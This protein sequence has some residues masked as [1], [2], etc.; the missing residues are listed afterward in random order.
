MKSELL[1]SRRLV[2]ATAFVAS[3]ASLFCALE[4]PAALSVDGQRILSDVP[5]VTTV[6]RAYIPIRAVA[7]GLGGATSYDAKSGNVVV[8]RGAD[9]LRMKVGSVQAKINGKQ[10]TLKR[11]PFVVRG[12]AMV[13]LNVVKRA[14]G[15]QVAYD[16]RDRKID[17]VTPG[18]IDA[19]AQEIR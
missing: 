13:G 6:S 9:V 14:F 5:P 1:P 12:R 4:Q 16:A 7:D 10:L 17:V 18:V 8:T 2:A 11:A 19:G 3:I 15:T